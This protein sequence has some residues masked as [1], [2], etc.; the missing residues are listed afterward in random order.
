MYLFQRL[1]VD[2]DTGRLSV[3]AEDDPGPDYQLETVWE[4]RFTPMTVSRISRVVSI[5]EGP[6]VPPAPLPPGVA[7]K[8]TPDEREK[9][10]A[11]FFEEFIKKLP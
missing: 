9:I 8:L 7:D 11:K 10:R 3:P 1:S 6:T 5:R 2:P 4:R